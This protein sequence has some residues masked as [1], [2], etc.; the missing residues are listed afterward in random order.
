MLASLARG[1][2][3]RRFRLDSVGINRRE[4]VNERVNRKGVAIHPDPSHVRAAETTH[5][6]RWPG[7]HVGWVSRSCELRNSQNQRRRRCQA[8]R[9]ATL[10]RAPER[11]CAAG[12]AE[13]QTPRMHG[14]WGPLGTREPRD[15][16]AV[17]GR[18]AADRWEKAMRSKAHMHGRG[19]SHSGIVCAEQRIDR[20][21]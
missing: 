3:G 5:L 11:E 7:V 2:W 15:P 4:V 19:D 9:K 14:N 13:S 10:R 17:R 21:G 8:N 12:P 20:E 1:W 16:V 6:K 18:E